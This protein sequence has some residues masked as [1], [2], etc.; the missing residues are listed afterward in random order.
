VTGVAGVP[1]DTIGDLKNVQHLAQVD[2]STA[3]VL[4]SAPSDS[5]RGPAKGPMTLQTIALP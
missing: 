1:Y 4:S 3:L 5:P 2:A